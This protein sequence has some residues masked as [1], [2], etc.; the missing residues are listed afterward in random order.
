MKAES[1]AILYRFH[2]E[3]MLR[4][5]C[6]VSHGLRRGVALV[7]LHKS[8]VR[9]EGIVLVPVHIKQYTAGDAQVSSR[10]MIWLCIISVGVCANVHVGGSL[11]DER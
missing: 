7:Q 10:T 2:F 3:R 4:Q 1:G 8:S 11:H 5:I 9:N 6:L